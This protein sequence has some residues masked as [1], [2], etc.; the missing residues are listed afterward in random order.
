[1]LQIIFAGIGTAFVLL[2]IE[3]FFRYSRS[4]DDYLDSVEKGQYMLPQLFFIGFGFIKQF[5]IDTY[6]KYALSRIQLF[7]ELKGERYSR[8]YFMV[9]FAGQFTYILTVLP[10]GFLMAA[11]ADPILAFLFILV[12]IVLAFYLDYDIKNKV[13]KRREDIMVSFPHVLSKMSLLINAGMPLHDVVGKLAYAK[14]ETLYTEFGI[15]QD[16]IRNGISERV[17]MQNL[18]DRCGIQEIRKFSSIM[19]QNME[20]G[21]SEMAKSLTEMADNVWRDRKNSVRQLGEKASAKLMLPIMMIFI[22]IMVMVL[23]PMFSSVG[24][25]I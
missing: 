10:I 2:W 9:N 23:V 21:S 13:E 20:K 4:Y 5:N 25:G 22:G 19:I 24:G 3:L 6:G 14:E 11:I 16:E 7:S 12:G 18:A 15:M 17:A 1:M 8:Y